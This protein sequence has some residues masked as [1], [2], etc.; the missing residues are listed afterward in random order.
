VVPERRVQS[1][2]KQLGS[3]EV[4]T[5]EKRSVE[6]VPNVA[7]VRIVNGDFHCRTFRRGSRNP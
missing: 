5:H 6:P 2:W 7:R 4:I 3:G 1:V